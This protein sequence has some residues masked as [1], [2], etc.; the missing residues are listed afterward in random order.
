MSDTTKRTLQ[1]YI[2]QTA[3]EVEA[4]KLQTTI[5]VLTKKIS[6]A[7][8]AG[9]DASKDMKKLG[10]AKTALASVQAQLD[11]GLTPSLN[12]QKNLVRQLA[13]EYGTLYQNTPEAAEKLKELQKQNDILKQMQTNVSGVTE[14]LE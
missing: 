4:K 12:Q 8:A 10:D 3:A 5:D 11:N 6:A 9:V 14:K 7:G 1:I 2:D 13:R